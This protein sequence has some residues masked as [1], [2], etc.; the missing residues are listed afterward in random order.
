[1]LKVKITKMRWEEWVVVMPLFQAR[2]TSVCPC[3]RRL[4]R[5]TQIW[6]HLIQAL[7][8]SFLCLGWHKG[9]VY[10]MVENPPFNPSWRWIIYDFG[11]SRSSSTAVMTV[12]ATAARCFHGIVLPF[13]VIAE[14]EGHL[15][16]FRY[17][18]FL[19]KFS[20]CLLNKNISML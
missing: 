7:P 17:Q 20:W 8:A 13:M 10:M 9:I 1:M 11:L 14:L 15:L 2:H 18:D 5:W 16:V 4:Y 12:K 3:C 6:A 19:G